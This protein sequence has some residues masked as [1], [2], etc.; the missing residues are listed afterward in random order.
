MR[1]RVVA[2]AA[3]VIAVCVPR[4]SIAQTDSTAQLSP[5]ERQELQ[6]R[7][8]MARK[9]YHEAE[10]IYTKLASEYPKDPGYPNAVGIAKQQQDDLKGAAQFYLRATKIDKHFATG[11]SNLG[12]TFYAQKQYVQAIRYYRRAISVDPQVAGFYT[13]LG[14]AY[15]AQKKYPEAFAEFQKAMAI[16][17]DIFEENDRN[18]SVMS[19][20]AVPDR[21]LFYFMLAKSYGLKADAMNCA[22]YLK[23][24]RD[25]GYKAT[26]KD[27]A[28]KS[29][30]A[31]RAD[32]DV[33]SLL[34]LMQPAPPQNSASAAPSGD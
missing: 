11:Y 1:S 14:Y 18:G 5:K 4:F 13:N 2:A 26:D 9:Q 28:D 22:A 17:P 3:L 15:F 24:A 23:R 20:K 8:D 33:K 21:G 19:Y 30:D 29:F 6:A 27:L 34:D 16:N 32:P 10:Q 31:V 25:E 7:I 12:T